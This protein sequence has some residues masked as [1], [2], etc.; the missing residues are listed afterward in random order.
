MHKKCTGPA[1][2]EPAYLPATEKYFHVRRSSSK[3]GHLAGDLLSRCRLCVNWDKLKS[4]GSTA[5]LV[6][7]RDARPI[8]LEAVNRVG[9]MELARRSGISHNS[10][11]AMLAGE[12]RFVQKAKLRA[13]LLE[14][15]S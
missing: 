13:V 1:H 3:G 4:P 14:L 2:D 12:R 15:I 9:L 11:A 8:Y 5:G 6:D 7:A 10:I